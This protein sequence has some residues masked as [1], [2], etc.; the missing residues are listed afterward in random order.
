[1]EFDEFCLVKICLN[2]YKGLVSCIY[3][4]LISE[5]LVLMVFDL[6]REFCYVLIIEKSFKVCMLKYLLVM[7]I[8]SKVW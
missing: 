8:I 3:I 2:V 4:L 7:W 1:M 5:D 6:V